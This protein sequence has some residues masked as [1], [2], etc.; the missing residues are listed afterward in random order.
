MELREGQRVK[1]IGK[2]WGP[3]Q[4]DHAVLLGIWDNQYLIQ[5]NDGSSNYVLREGGYG[6]EAIPHYWEGDMVRLTGEGWPPGLRDKIV[7]VVDSGYDNEAMVMTDLG[8]FYI[9]DTWSVTPVGYLRDDTENEYLVSW[10]VQDSETAIILCKELQRLAEK[11]GADPSAI[12]V[13]LK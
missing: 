5:L 8:K 6:I 11:M 4:Y 2:N 12:T 7:N 9:T 10:A 1:L 13:T 3:S